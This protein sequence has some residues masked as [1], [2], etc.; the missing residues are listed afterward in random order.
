[1]SRYFERLAAAFAAVLIMT[2]TFSVTVSVPQQDAMRASAAAPI[3]V[4]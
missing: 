2:T 4:A 1:M 3:S